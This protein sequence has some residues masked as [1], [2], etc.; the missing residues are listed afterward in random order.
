MTKLQVYNILK[1]SLVAVLFMFAFELLFSFDSITDAISNYIASMHGFVL[2][3]I[4]YLIMVIQVCLIPI[5]V[6]VVVNACILI[7][8]MNLSLTSTD[9][10]I[11]ILVTMLAYMTGVALAYLLGRKFGSKAVKWCA[12]SEE[13]YQK[14]VN[15]FN[16][17]GKWYYALT[18][19]LPI[20]PDDILCIV[21]G[22]VKMDFTFFM[23]VNLICRFLGLI[24]MIYSLGFAQS[25]ND[26][27]FPWTLL[28]WGVALVLNVI[29]LIVMKIML[30]RKQA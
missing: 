29:A 3:L 13:D 26:G 19:L 11:F 8:S 16:N 15:V 1:V 14:W 10:W 25:L 12:G 22:G 4:I 17:K 18:V 23:I 21:A 24:T 6:Y 7:D 28:A 5:P 30:K 9:G 2:Y 20:F 27:G